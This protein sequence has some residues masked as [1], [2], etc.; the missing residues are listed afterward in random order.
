[1]PFADGS[2]DVVLSTFGVMF[3][4]NQEKAAAELLRTCRSGGR[5]AMANWTPEGFIGQLFKTIGRHVPPP[6]GV[7]SPAL[8]G[9]EARLRELFGVGASEIQCSKR[10]F[11]FRYRSA[12]HWLEVF[13][14]W[15]G[16]LY[17][18][19][20]ALGDNGPALDKDLRQLLARF[21]RAGDAALVV[22]GEYLEVVIQRA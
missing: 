2:F 7:K 22:P 10:L 18:A 19:F 16:P 20:A 5:I 9:T 6:A 15:Y 13:R 17:K 8:W 3:T 1:L 21:N 4:P 11:N 14:T 12:D